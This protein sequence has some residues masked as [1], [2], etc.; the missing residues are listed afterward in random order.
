MSLP[1]LLT[2]AVLAA[3]LIVKGLLLETEGLRGLGFF[4][5]AWVG[6]ACAVAGFVYVLLFSGPL[7]RS[8]VALFQGSVNAREYTVEMRVETG[9]PLVGKTVERAGLRHLPGL[10]L[11]EILR[12]EN[13]LAGVSPQEVLQ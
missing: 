8:R 2:F 10:Y 13:T 3:C 12:A 11:I 7:L 9:S 1:I 6:L 4:E 5:L